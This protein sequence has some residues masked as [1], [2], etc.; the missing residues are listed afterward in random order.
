MDK[1]EVK[2]KPVSPYQMCVNNVAMYI[3]SNPSEHYPSTIDAFTASS[4]LAI[5]FCMSKEEVLMHIVNADV[6]E[7]EVE[8]IKESRKLAE[9]IAR[10][11]RKERIK[12]KM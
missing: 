10:I 12:D 2:M 4:V 3:R 6:S 8:V 11:G 9:T 7:D 5:A 1:G